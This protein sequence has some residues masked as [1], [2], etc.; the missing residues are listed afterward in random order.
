MMK[1]EECGIDEFLKMADKCSDK[2]KDKD[3]DLSSDKAGPRT[4]SS[5]TDRIQT[6]RMPSIRDW[7]LQALQRVHRDNHTW[8]D[9]EGQD[10][11]W[12]TDFRT[13]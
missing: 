2:D 10:C 5:Q 7:V 3:K 4:R 12:R 9:D 6:A 13:D 8:I 1:N 11:F